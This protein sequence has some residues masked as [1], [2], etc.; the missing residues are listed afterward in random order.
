MAT[1]TPSR[2]DLS[3]TLS[4]LTKTAQLA[5]STA[6][7]Q[8]RDTSAIN[9]SINLSKSMLSQTKKEGSK[10]GTAVMWVASE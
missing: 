4:S 1:K 5:S 6:K 3:K 7:A 10:T 2:S 9:N 8:G